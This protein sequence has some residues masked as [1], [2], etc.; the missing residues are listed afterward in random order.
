MLRRVVGT[1][2]AWFIYCVRCEH[3]VRFLGFDVLSLHYPISPV[4]ARA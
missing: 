2:G 3:R 1:L 4:D